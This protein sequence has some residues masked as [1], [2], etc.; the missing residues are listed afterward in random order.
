MANSLD[1]LKL[2]E[3]GRSRDYNHMIS[4]APGLGKMTLSNSFISL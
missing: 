2:S 4:K 3:V 1:C